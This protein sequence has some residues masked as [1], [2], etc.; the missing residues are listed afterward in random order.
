MWKSFVEKYQDKII[1]GT[2]YYAF[3]KN[4]N[5][6][7]NFNRRPQLIREL[8]ETDEEHSYVGKI[9]KGINLDKKLRD[10]IYRENF[11]DFLDSPTK[12]DENWLALQAE[13]VLAEKKFRRKIDEPDAEYILKSLEKR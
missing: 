5:W 12:I 7:V 6:E 2:D 8:F 1:Y 10:K 3:P 9:F 13:K 11:M 4:E